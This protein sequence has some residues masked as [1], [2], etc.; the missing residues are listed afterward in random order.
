MYFQSIYITI[1]VGSLRRNLRSSSSTTRPVSSSSFRRAASMLDS[2][3]VFPSN[4]CHILFITFP[5]H[6]DIRTPSLSCTIIMT[7]LAWAALHFISFLRVQID[8]LSA[9]LLLSDSLDIASA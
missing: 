7:N 8:T 5:Y 1:V 2:L 4:D 9:T 3:S 6:K